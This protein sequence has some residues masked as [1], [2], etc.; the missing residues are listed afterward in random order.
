[1]KR[2]EFAF[3][4]RSSVQPPS[5]LWSLRMKSI[6]A[7]E[8]LP[9]DKEA[10]ILWCYTI[11]LNAVYILFHGSSWWRGLLEAVACLFGWYALHSARSPALR[12]LQSMEELWSKLKSQHRVAAVALLFAL[13][14]S[15]PAIRLACVSL[16]SY[17]GMVLQ[18]NG[19]QRA[20]PGVIV[21]LK[22]EEELASALSAETDKVILSVPLPPLAA[23]PG[24]TSAP[25][26]SSHQDRPPSLPANVAPPKQDFSAVCAFSLALLI[27]LVS[28]LLDFES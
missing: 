19:G 1:M 3:V 5:E 9:L 7:Q 23:A 25:V 15:L 20:K 21:P 6:R 2:V 13:S 14:I 11:A 28:F 18:A 22:R 27:L 8:R 4:E 12:W 17:K 24:P 26:R 10:I 16:L